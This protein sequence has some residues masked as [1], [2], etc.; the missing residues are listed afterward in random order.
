[1][2][3]VNNEIVIEAPLD[4]VWNSMNE[5]ENWPNLFTEYASAEILD[6]EDHKVTFRL[7][8]H[9]DPD[10]GGQVWSWV[11]ERTIYPET[12]SSCSWRIETG[13]F[14]YMKI[15]W[16]FE[17]VPA[18]TRMRWAQCFT[19][20]P[21]A[22]ADDVTATEYLNRNTRIQMAAVKERLE[23]IHGNRRAG[24]KASLLGCH[25]HIHSQHD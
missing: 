15:N 10:A 8:T 11:S 1:M 4:A 25:A 12:Y 20:K 23:A 19:M 6:R 16:E 14:E 7:T 3:H 24:A 21:T 2:A 5:I 13:P 17:R 18:G 9:P 22:P